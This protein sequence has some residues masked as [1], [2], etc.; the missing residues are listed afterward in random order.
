MRL[1]QDCGIRNE[2]IEIYD[3]LTGEPVSLFR[4]PQSQKELESSSIQPNEV[5]DAAM[6]LRAAC[7]ACPETTSNKVEND[8]KRQE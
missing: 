2:K 5:K 8:E 3:P 6:P 7:A 4:L 1:S